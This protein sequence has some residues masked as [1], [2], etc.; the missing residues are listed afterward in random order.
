M[1]SSL[2]KNDMPEIQLCWSD[3]S[4]VSCSMLQS[5]QAIVDFSFSFPLRFRLVSAAPCPL[6]RAA[7]VNLSDGSPYHRRLH[8]SARLSNFSREGVSKGGGPSCAARRVKTQETPLDTATGIDECGCGCG[9]I[10]S[11]IRSRKGC[12]FLYVSTLPCSIAQYGMV[13]Y[14]FE[15]KKLVFWHL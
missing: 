5:T 7:T 10:S 12:I 13:T 2:F 4:Q 14:N 6:F 3:Q 15:Y 11:S 1:L 8:F 9:T